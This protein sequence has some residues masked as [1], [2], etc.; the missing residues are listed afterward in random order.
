MISDYDRVY[1][2]NMQPA[3]GKF[4]GFA[5][6]WVTGI[7]GAQPNGYIKCSALWVFVFGANALQVFF[8]RKKINQKENVQS[9]LSVEGR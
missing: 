8:M 7:L 3:S 2:A 1:A 4:D 9:W 5:F 6:P